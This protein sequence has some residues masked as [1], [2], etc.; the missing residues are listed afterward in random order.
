MAPKRPEKPK[1]HIKP[2]PWV[3]YRP[4]VELENMEAKEKHYL[5]LIAGIIMILSA[6]LIFYITTGH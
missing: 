3:L 1:G 2:L 4:E 6:I 5:K